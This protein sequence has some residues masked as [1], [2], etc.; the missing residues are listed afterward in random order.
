MISKEKQ[1]SQSNKEA[2]QHK[3][4]GELDNL[5]LTIIDLFADIQEDISK[6]LYE[7]YYDG[8]IAGVEEERKS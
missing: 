3:I 7:A 5:D 6:L 4:E 1:L 8:V 2:L